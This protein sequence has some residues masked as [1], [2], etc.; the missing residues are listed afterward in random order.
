MTASNQQLVSGLLARVAGGGS[1]G[2]SL[3]GSAGDLPAIEARVDVDPEDV[4][5]KAWQ[6]LEK[7]G[8]PPEAVGRALK[9]TEDRI[10]VEGDRLEAF[11]E[12]KRRRVHRAL[13]WLIL[14]VDEKDLPE[15]FRE[16]AQAQR[17]KRGGKRRGPGAKGGSGAN[18]DG[19]DDDGVDR[20]TRD[21]ADALRR[22]GFPEAVALRLRRG[23]R[24]RSVARARGSV[25]GAR[26]RSFGGSSPGDGRAG[27]G[28]GW[29]GHGSRG[30]V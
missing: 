14:N 28:W 11:N 1:L 4:E 17:K 8:F 22:A 3:G 29:G 15:A 30:C 19:A 9:A 27:R 25:R 5:R 13:D 20:A 12:Q 2:S 21:V 26:P 10:A 6:A 23:V 18:D 7:K 16:E 24:R